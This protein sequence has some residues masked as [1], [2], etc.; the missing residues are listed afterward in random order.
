[1]L[2]TTPWTSTD[3][4]FRGVKT[5][6][7]LP[8]NWPLIHVMKMGD[9]DKQSPDWIHA[10][11]TLCC[12]IHA[13]VK[14]GNAMELVVKL[15]HGLC[16]ASN[17]IKEYS[18]TR[19]LRRRV[20][21]LAI[22]ILRGRT[23]QHGRRKL[24]TKQLGVESSSKRDR[25][26]LSQLNQRST[27]ANA[28]FVLSSTDP[29][30]Q[31]RRSHLLPTLRSDDLFQRITG[32]LYGTTVVQMQLLSKTAAELI[33][34]QV[35]KYVRS[36]SLT[37]NQLHE[38]VTLPSF[39][40]LSNL[41][42]ITC[43][44]HVGCECL[45]QSTVLRPKKMKDSETPAFVLSLPEHI[46]IITRFA[47]LLPNEFPLLRSISIQ[48]FLCG[49]SP[50]EVDSIL[51]GIHSKSEFR[52]MSLP[53]NNIGDEGLLQLGEYI[54]GNTMN[55]RK[56]LEVLD[57]RQ[58]DI[59]SAGLLRLLPYIRMGVFRCL[60]RLCLGG[61]SLTDTGFQ[62]LTMAIKLG[63]LPELEFIGIEYNHIADEITFVELGQALG[64]YIC[65]NIKNV[66]FNDNYLPTDL[67]RA[68]F[69]RGLR[70]QRSMLCPEFA[71]V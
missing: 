60:K 63:C 46:E 21:A 48:G 10:R 8:V 25:K 49:P 35:I 47:H 18:N 28:D 9:I 38:A 53:A 30:A 40:R 6:S 62:A 42:R 26:G 20:A 55:G 36:L 69:I 31:D 44:S 37:C 23:K 12:R 7:Q 22:V 16:L 45:G 5:Q 32:F 2:G 57:L 52:E 13:I 39:T 58:N 27:Q 43:I 19:T 65:P 15:E 59:T 54:H 3:M 64:S 67:A 17:G 66:S 29:L 50:N 71:T 24:G 14:A 4:E 68:A 70:E 56:G 33:A 41:E 51:R 61:N 1:M 34:P 11:Q